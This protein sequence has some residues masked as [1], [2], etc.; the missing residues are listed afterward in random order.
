MMGKLINIE[1]DGGEK[2][3]ALLRSILPSSLNQFYD[4]KKLRVKPEVALLSH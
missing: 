3:L 4:T 2:W 1:L